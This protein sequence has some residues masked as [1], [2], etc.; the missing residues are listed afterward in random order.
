MNRTSVPSAGSQMSAAHTATGH[1]VPVALG[2][3]SYDILIGPGLIGQAGRLIAERLGARACAIV[4]DANVAKHHLTSLEVA[5]GGHLR[6]AGTLQMPPGEATKNFGHLQT[7]CEGLL[8]SGLERKD[9]VIALGGGVI[10]DLTG[11]A[12]AVL[13]RGI[14]FVQ[15]PTSLLA[16]VDS[17][18]G[19]KT[20]I[21]TRHGKNLVGAF[22]QPS[23]VLADTDVLRTLP[24]RELRAGYAEVVKYG[25]LGDAAFFDW[26]Q[27]GGA[28]ALLAGDEAARI[29]AIEISCRMKADI[30]ARDE[31]ETGDRMLLNLGHTFGHALEAWAGFSGRL[32]HGE[33]VAIG[34]C[35]A[36]EMSEQL[37]HA[38]AGTAETV[39]RHIA[40]VGL[41]N[42]IGDIPGLGQ[43]RPTVKE[44]M[45]LM[46][47]DKKV[48]GGRMT[49]ILANAI[50]QTFITRDVGPDVVQAF[51]AREIPI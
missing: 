9:V 16:Q 27:Q 45:D 50:G 44:L 42:A 36:F 32:L 26:L 23:L 43:G 5:I 48:S 12:A 22:H 41:P 7:V 34:I 3:R 39:R 49:F 29:H 21:N 37:G 40:A 38:P 25:L 46:A 33:A 35:L 13:R 18:V 4:T 31:T 28:A 14:R 47:Q 51:L 6:H 24:A 2:D 8:D 17:S 1:A 19:G 20:G 11:F 10:G 15:I 30:V